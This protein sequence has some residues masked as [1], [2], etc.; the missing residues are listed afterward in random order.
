MDTSNLGSPRNAQ[1][2]EGR[3]IRYEKKR[4]LGLEFLFPLS[5]ASCGAAE[6]ALI[7]GN[8]NNA[9]GLSLLG[10]IWAPASEFQAR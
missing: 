10:S 6:A 3:P 9:L 8:R 2:H 7:N 4:W 5:V 1:L